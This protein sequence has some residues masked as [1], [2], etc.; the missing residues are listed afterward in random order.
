MPPR[1]ARVL[2][3]AGRSSASPAAQ[4][5][6]QV[7]EHPVGDLPGGAT[8]GHMRPIRRRARLMPS[9]NALNVSYPAVDGWPAGPLPLPGREL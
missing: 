3:S 2:G 8:A 7:A 1:T 9:Q 6:Q 4:Q 5:G